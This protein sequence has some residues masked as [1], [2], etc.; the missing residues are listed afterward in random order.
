MPR[1]PEIKQLPESPGVYRFY[2]SKGALLYIGK[3]KNIKKRVSSYFTKSAG[4]PARIRVMVKLIHQVEFTTV[5]TE[6]D[7]FLL[8]NSLIKQYQPRYNIDLKD[9]KSYPYIVIVKEPFPRIFLTRNPRQDGSAY[10]GPFTSVHQVRSMLELIKKMYP[11]RSCTLNLSPRSLKKNKYKV[12]LEYHIGNCLGPCAGLQSEDEYLNNIQQ[13]RQMIK[14][15]L[16]MV[17]QV[18]ESNMKVAAENLDFEEAGRIKK[19]LD[20][21]AQYVATSCIVNPTQGNLE[22]FG[23]VQEDNRAFVHYFRIV[24]GTIVRVR[25]LQ[26]QA[27]LEESPEDL[28]THGI[29]DILDGKTEGIHIICPFKVPLLA[30]TANIIVPKA[31]E[32]KKLL[33]LAQR[34][35]MEQK[36]KY[37]NSQSK[38]VSPSSSRI[39]SQMKEDL[40][41]LESP[42]HIECFDNSNLQG[43]N[44][45][46]AVVVFRQ[47]KPSVKE[48]RTFNIKT[49]T[50]PDDFASMKEVV[51][52]RYRRMLE[53]GEPLPQLIV[54]DGGK[55]QLSAAIEALRE[56]DLFGK[57]QIISI[58]KRLEE[59]YYPGDAY[60]LH[61][62][63]KSETLKVLQHIRNEAHRFAIGFHRKKRSSGSFKTQL[64]NIEGIGDKTAEALL[65]AFR[66]EKKIRQASE[67][68]LAAV[69]GNDKARR[70]LRAL[71]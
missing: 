40:R 29:L 50:G 52:R 64:T 4:M 59:I 9:D 44:P 69:I 37:T 70:I 30:N 7:A 10:F 13:I 68:A 43:S 24:E 54:I 33:D 35:A 38:T 63:K 20:F 46:A 53:A 67:E 15:N 48:Y 5:A 51:G 39:L 6:K 27:K 71:S 11:I 2:D 42:E 19:Q 31:G 56:L 61:I 36:I 8:E 21:L 1:L 41:M 25:S 12:C 45:V 55:G 23:Y 47:A 62:S 3:A 57:I 17:R 22:V 16:G 65:I 18:L 14:G 28:L 58:A 49:V 66:S 32:K 26:L 34:N 60:P